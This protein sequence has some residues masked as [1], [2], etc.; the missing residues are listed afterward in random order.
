MLLLNINGPINSGKTTVSKILERI[1]PNAVFI[2]VDELLSDE[3]EAT[4]GLS[5]QQGWAERQKRLKEKLLD[6]K[7][8]R[9][10]ETV[11]F[12]Y[13]I[14]DNSYYEWSSMA[15][16]NTQFMNITLAPS[17][18]ECLKNRGMRVLTDWEKNRIR[19]MYAEGYQN[20]PYA[21]FIVNNDYQTPEETAGIITAFVQKKPVC[22]LLSGFLGAGKTTYA[23]RLAQC[24]NAIH[25]N[26]DEWC[27]Q[28]FSPA[29]Y[30]N[31]WQECFAKS[32]D[33]L[34][35]KARQYAL[36]NK[37]II[38]DA[39]F[40]SKQSRCQAVLKSRDAGFYPIICYIFAS[41]EI[42]KQ[43]ISQRKGVIAEYNLQHFDELKK[44][45]E[46]PDADERFLIV[47][48]N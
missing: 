47:N 28:V 11:I 29:E 37:S 31:H 39:G 38:F 27:M 35:N 24:T 2:E 43:R 46:I 40:W 1:L 36:E 8:S 21:D 30:E 41:D 23:K 45:F 44:M 13:P 16:E 19:E 48:N 3:E 5:L 6:L 17:L 42:L 12:A 20:R 32:F 7:Q 33:M 9:T 4:A 25:L 18:D 10:Y 22:Y 15:D 34:W 14:G 26:P